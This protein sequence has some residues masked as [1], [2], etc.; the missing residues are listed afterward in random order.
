VCSWRDVRLASEGVHR[1]KSSLYCSVVRGDNMQTG[2]FD[3]LKKQFSSYE[4]NFSKDDNMVEIVNPFGNENVR[5]EYVTE[6]DFT[7]YIVFFAFQH[8]HMRDEEAVINYINVIITG[9]IF[10]IEYFNNDARCFG[11]DISAEELKDLSYEVL[12]QNTGYY[13]TTKLKDFVDS[14]KV[15]GW[16]SD[17]NFDAVFV[18]GEDDSI[19]IKKL[20]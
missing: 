5:V 10:S 7:P 20:N 15:R 3:F 19:T 16:H 1:K 18:T 12:E 13:G 8:C 6:D 4:M 14:F 9:N 17:C 11:R 2:K